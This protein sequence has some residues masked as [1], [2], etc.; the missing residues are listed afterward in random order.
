MT[1]EEATRWVNPCG[2]CWLG[3]CLCDRAQH[4]DI[5]ALSTRSLPVK[6]ATEPTHRKARRAAAAID[7]KEKWS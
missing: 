4:R 1:N 7:R 6:E 3:T 2:R 5:G